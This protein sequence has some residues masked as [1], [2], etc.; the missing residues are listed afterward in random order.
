M[1]GRKRAASGPDEMSARRL[2]SIRA[3]SRTSCGKSS[4]RAASGATSM[5]GASRRSR[6]RRPMSPA[7][8]PSFSCSAR[9]TRP[10][11]EP[12]PHHLACAATQISAGTRSRQRRSRCSFPAVR[13]D[14]EFYC[15]GGFCGRTSCTAPARR[16]GADGL[17]VVNPRYIPR[18][19]ADRRSRA[20]A[21]ARTI[22]SAAFY[23]ARRSTRCCLDRHRRRYRSPGAHQPHPRGRPPP[24]RADFVSELNKGLGTWTLPRAQ[25]PCAS[26]TSALRPTSAALAA[27]LRRVRPISSGRASGMLAGSVI[28]RASANG[29]ERAKPICSPTILFDGEFAAR[30]IELGRNERAPATPELCAFFDELAPVRVSS[31]PASS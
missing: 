18:R 15:D 8:G 30:L 17:I 6:C 11:M 3:A 2:S 22:R 24:F 9:S 10:P 14:G 19:A 25:T 12:R 23:S 5:P 13:I 4:R 16:L 28:R 20:R 31:A 21:P 29:K 26:C 1:V 27:R 7:V